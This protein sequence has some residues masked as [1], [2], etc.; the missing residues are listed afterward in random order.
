MDYKGIFDQRGDSYNTAGAAYP[1]ARAAERDLLVDWLDP[2]A[3]D[4]ICDAPAGG[5]YLAQGLVERCADTKVI[6]VEP[7]KVFSSAIPGGFQV[8]N[9]PLDEMRLATGLCTAVGS[10]AG[11]HHL[12]DR[13]GVFREWRRI[14]GPRGRLA[15]ADVATGTGAA[16]FLNGFVDRYVPG[17]HK[18][19]F[20]TPGDLSELMSLNG[21]TDVHERRA[22]VPW[23]FDSE[24]SLVDF[25]RQLFGVQRA[26]QQ[27]L[28]KVLVECVG[29][30][31]A[32]GGSI[33]LNWELQFAHGLRNL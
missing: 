11:L 14:L 18:G 9:L 17:G 26:P 27:D 30:S 31:S 24:R 6:C 1:Q 12:T 20:F 16:E 19:M 2:Q 10:L 15:V 29:I 5:G 22:A 13:T 32:E 33:L 8:I 21:F 3:G 23:H 28:L 7:S 4:L 25:C